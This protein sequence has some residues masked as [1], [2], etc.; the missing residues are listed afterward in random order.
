[1]IFVNRGIH[2]DDHPHLRFRGA[3][4]TVP[5]WAPGGTNSPRSLD[6][7]GVIRFGPKPEMF[8]QFQILNV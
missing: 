2:H 4:T 3:A 5:E 8:W 6:S 7:F 1:M